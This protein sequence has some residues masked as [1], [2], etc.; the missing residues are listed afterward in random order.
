MTNLL[1]GFLAS[2]LALIAFG[3]SELY[4]GSGRSSH[5][6]SPPAN[7]TVNL[8]G[9]HIRIDYYA[10]SMHGRRIMGGLVP[11]GRVWCTGAN[12]ATTLTTEADLEIHGDAGA[13]ET[14]LKIPK[15]SYSIW[16]VPG[17]TDWTLIVNKQTGQSHLAYDKT[18]DFGRVRMRLATLPS[19]VET[20]KIQL[21]GEGN[22]GALA[23]IWEK[24]EISVRFSLLP[25]T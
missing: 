7:T 11:Y 17:E 25:S 14:A 24:S 10:P 4:Y 9:K 6:T 21:T 20:L 18:Q 8:G 2:G 23:V 22:Q 3:Q 15:G 19:P 13:G 12:W 16:T 1:L 5:Y